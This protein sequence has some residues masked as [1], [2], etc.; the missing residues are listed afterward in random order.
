M[1]CTGFVTGGLDDFPGSKWCAYCFENEQRPLKSCIFG[2]NFQW[3][4][5]QSGLSKAQNNVLVQFLF[6]LIHELLQKNLSQVS[7][8]NVKVQ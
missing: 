5:N 8:L 4:G 3:C 2:Q 6:L 1:I 7:T